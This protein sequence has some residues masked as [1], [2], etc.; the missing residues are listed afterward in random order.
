MVEDGR[1]AAMEFLFLIAIMLQGGAPAA[2][3]SL[4]QD[5]IV[6]DAVR[7]HAVLDA[8]VAAWNRGDVAAF[9]QGYWNSPDVEFVGANGITRG[10]RRVLDRYHKAYPDRAAMGHLDFSDIEVQ[11]LGPDAAL[12]VGQFHL[13][14]QNDAPSGVFTLI[15]RKFPDGWKIIHDHTSQTAS[16]AAPER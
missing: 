11:S 16:A 3:P 5:A 2:A 4:P 14:R 10:W 8:Q 15:F 13:Q 12:V 6:A 7:I 9:M 1:E